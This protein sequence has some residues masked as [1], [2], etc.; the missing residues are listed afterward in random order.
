MNSKIYII[1]LLATVLSACSISKSKSFK[2]SYFQIDVDS[3]GYITGMYNTTR[4]SR[5]FSPTDQPSPLL[6]LYDGK[7]KHYYYPQ[8]GH[9]SHSKKQY[10]LEFENGSE[11]TI[12]LD[13]K[14]SYFKLTLV[15]L[16]QRDNIDGIQWGNYYTNITNLL[17]EIIGVARDTTA[18]VGYA[19]G[20]LALED[21]TIGGESRFTS[22]TG[23]GGY[24]AHSPDP[25]SYPL[26]ITLHEGKQF[27]MGGDGIN[28][29]AFYNRKEP[30]YRM[31]YGSTAGVDCNGRINI[32]YHSRD[33]RMANMIYSPEGVPILENNEPNHLMRQAVPEVDYI[34]SSIA[35]WGSPDSIALMDVIQDIVLKEKLPYTTFQGK[36]VKDP[37]SF[38]P[39]LWTY[40]NQYDS[41]ASYA[42]QMGLRVIHAYDQGFLKPDRGNEGYIDGKDH[43]RKTF[44]FANGNLSHKEY[45]DLLARDGLILGRT[46]ITNSMA[47][48]T[49]DCSPLPSDSACIQHRRFLMESMSETDTLIYIDDPTHLEEIACWEGHCKELNMVKIEKELIH[50]LGVTTTKPYRLLN[51]TRGYWNT[52]PAPHA[53]GESVDKMQVTVGW[54][55]EGLVPNLELQDEIGRH[56]GDLAHNSGLGVLDF[57]GQEFLF[58]S[59]FGAY[60]VKRFC[61]SMFD[62][63]KKYGL[64]DLRFT[65]ATLSEGS[66]HYQSIWNVGGGTNMYDAKKRVWGSSTSQGKDLRDVTYANFF[67]SSFGVNFQIAANSTVEEFEHIEAT[68]VGYG[69]TYFLKIGQKDVESCPQKYAIFDVIRNWEEARKANAF[70][71]HIRKRL[72]DPSLSWRLERNSGKSGWTLHRMENDTKMESFVLSSLK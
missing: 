6:A 57:D 34:G 64:P 19:I 28:D 35:L 26:P 36:W 38:M 16:T 29:V 67:P 61:R 53:K 39:D 12:R 65:G 21:N 47:P 4:E 13:A 66:W 54:S 45:A 5:N 49:K 18:T 58:H 20:A 9:Y 31:V 17:G 46:S 72:Q 51:V 11:A 10:K 7:L 68:A 22:E 3:K 25:A 1:A 43:S 60:S 62:Q 42:K 63:V 69:S 56:Y 14:N 48:G 59:G 41:I 52:R 71:T 30:F 50:Y 24:I 70:P 44:R 33:R 32:R 27:T 40:G 2:T 8:K 37:T 55:Y 23:A 15:D